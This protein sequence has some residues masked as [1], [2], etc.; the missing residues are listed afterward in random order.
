MSHDHTGAWW[1]V[2]SSLFIIILLMK[3]IYKE[4]LVPYLAKRKDKKAH[5]SG[6]CCH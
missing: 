3:G 4:N 1:E 5:S 2:L 6:S